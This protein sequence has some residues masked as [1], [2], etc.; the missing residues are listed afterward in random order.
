MVDNCAVVVYDLS[1][2]DSRFAVEVRRVEQL[3]DGTLIAPVDAT[4]YSCAYSTQIGRVA[5]LN[6]AKAFCELLG[7]KIVK[8]DYLAGRL[9]AW[10]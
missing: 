8:F 5:A 2:K 10:Q 9:A 1:T 6:R 4:V 7:L 3:G